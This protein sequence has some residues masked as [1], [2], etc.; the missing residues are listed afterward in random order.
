[1]TDITDQIDAV[2]RK[3]DDYPVAAGP[4]RS[5]VLRRVYDAAVDD[6]WDACTTAPRIS[7]WLA[8]VGGDLRVGGSFTVEGQ[9]TGTILRCEAPHLLKVTWEYEP[10]SVT[11]VELHL[12]ENDKGGVVLELRHTSPAAT[13]DE[14]VRRL[15]PVGP[16]GIGGG[17]D[18]ALAALDGLLAD[19]DFDPARWRDTPQVQEF[20]AR[21]LQAWGAESQAAW[22]LGDEDVA[23][24]VAFV[25]RLPPR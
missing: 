14:L 21:S 20:I 10:D 12:T 13:V 9:A 19:P 22:G 15:G 7:R 18:V 3:I 4:G 23:K 5:L 8:P 17:W 16:V 2:Q 1:M 24:V 25:R 11:E 6:L